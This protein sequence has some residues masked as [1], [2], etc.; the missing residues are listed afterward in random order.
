VRHKRGRVTTIEVPVE[1]WER[2]LEISKQQM[3]YRSPYWNKKLRAVI[4]ST[5][6]RR[7]GWSFETYGHT[8]LNRRAPVKGLTFLEHLKRK[9]LAVRPGGG[10]SSTARDLLQRGRR[11]AGPVRGPSHSHTIQPAN[12]DRLPLPAKM[13]SPC[14]KPPANT[15]GAAF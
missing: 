8:P 11:E 6:A 3:A 14:V 15:E 12:G 4:L 5:N 2:L 9:Y 10:C 7:D 13:T 1:E